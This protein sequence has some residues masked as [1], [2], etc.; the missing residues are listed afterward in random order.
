M[1]L[2]YH[3]QVDKE[4]TLKLRALLSELP[5]CCTTFFRGIEPRTSSTHKGYF[6]G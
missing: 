5:Q 3:E 6:S 2:K 1:A 4:N